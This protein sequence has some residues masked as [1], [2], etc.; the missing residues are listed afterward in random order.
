MEGLGV[1]E[2]DPTKKFPS[3]LREGP[4]EGALWR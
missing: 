4:G 2:E 1:R 3:P